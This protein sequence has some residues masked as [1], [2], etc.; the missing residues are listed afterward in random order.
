MQ[1]F[2]GTGE[3]LSTR[4]YRRQPPRHDGI[5]AG[6]HVIAHRGPVELIE[7]AAYLMSSIWT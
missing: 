5:T 6:V 4:I 7:G 2:L 1:V 3:A